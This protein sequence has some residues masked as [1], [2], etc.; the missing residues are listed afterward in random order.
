[1]R[2]LLASL[3]LAVAGVFALAAPASAEEPVITHMDVFLADRITVGDRVTYVVTIESDP[4]IEFS[5]VQSSLPA[6]V[7]VV[8]VPDT[9]SQ[10][11]DGGRVRIT[12]TFLLAPFAPGEIELPPMTLRYFGLEV[13]G[14]ELL[15]PPTQF[16]VASVLPAEP[17]FPP[18][19]DLK[20]QAVIGAPAAGWIVPALAAT[21]GALALVVLLIY[22]RTRAWKRSRTAFVPAPVLVEDLPEDRARVVLDTAG[23][24]FSLEGDYVEYY[25]SIGVTVRRYLT[26]R[27]GFPAFA[28]TTRELE[29]EML[30]RGLDRWQ[31]RVASGLLEQCDSVVYANYRPAA[32]RADADLT[33][34]YEIVE[35]S[36]PEPQPEE[37]AAR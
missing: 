31:V 16:S 24:G 26:E 12:M 29:A 30:N 15:T 1:M 35:M 18:P 19:R 8:D 32:E 17:A 5:L 6:Y 28:L 22:L 23:A 11:I 21:T 9:T 37:A 13:A 25:S 33:A 14:G 4:G 27:Y 34:A 36:R 20:P 3:L 2:A 7:E 10:P